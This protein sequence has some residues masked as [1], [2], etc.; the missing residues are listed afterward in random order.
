MNDTHAIDQPASPL[1]ELDAYRAEFPI[2]GGKTYLNSNSLGA[3]SVRAIEER[4]RFEDLWNEL[5]ASA[6]YE[7]WVRK[8]D[9]VRAAFGRTIGADADEIALMPSV[10]AT[11][12]AVAGAVAGAP[13]L[14]DRPKVVVTE[15]DFPTVG[16]HFLSREALGAEVEIVPSPDGVQVPLDA[17]AKAVDDRTALLVT[18]HVFFSTGAIQD[19]G[20]LTSIAHEA[21]AYLLLDAYQ[22]NGQVPIDAHALEVDFLASGAL[23]WLCG[24]P[25]LAYLYA[26]RDLELAPT[27]LSWFGVEDQFGFDLRDATPR[28]D[29]RRFEMGT[30]P[31]G[32]AY[33]A[34]GGL[35][36][37]EEAGIGRIRE[38]NR[39]LA[40]DLRRRLM[41]AGLT[42]HEARDPE[43]R[44]ALVLA[45]HPDPQAAVGW[46][47][48]NDVVIDC[49]GPFIRF[50]PH[51]YNTIGDN[52]RA[53]EV[54]K[55]FR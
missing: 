26:R 22:S 21:G 20:A 28:R 46:L 16:H 18:S 42:L 6:W 55:R 54:L 34:A 9:E 43:D 41:D 8:L 48:S 30:P 32:A 10:S 49:R 25:G 17:I 36:V 24:G 38:H 35:A 12:A 19:A 33:T 5:G 11:L 52:E 3:L 31:V 23:K 47:A 1:S 51:F 53:V 15:L 27:T 45:R 40:D 39:G 29:A 50:S 13:H 14:R 44:S 7:L 4:R 37:V 2:L